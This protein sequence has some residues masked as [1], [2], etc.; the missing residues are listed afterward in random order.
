MLR[1]SQ[2]S[3]DEQENQNLGDVLRQRSLAHKADKDE[4]VRSGEHR[5]CVSNFTHF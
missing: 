2:V 5:S 3:D 4:E 1:S